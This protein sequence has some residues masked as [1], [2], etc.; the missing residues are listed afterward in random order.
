MWCR[1]SFGG[2]GFA[3]GAGVAVNPE[4]NVVYAANTATDVI[5]A[6]GLEP[7]APPLVVAD[8]ASEVTAT[9]VILGGEVDPDSLSPEE[10]AKLGQPA[11]LDTKYH[12]EYSTEP[13]AACAAADTCIE[14]PAGSIAPSFD[15]GSVVPAPVQGLTP[16]RT[17]HYR[18][19]ADNE[20][21]E[22]EHKRGEGEERTFTTRPPVNL[23]S[24]MAG[25]GN[26]SPVQKHGALI[27]PIDQEGVIM[28]A[29]DGDAIT[30]HAN[31]PIEPEPQGA[32]N[33]V[34]I[35]STRT[36]AGWSIARHRTVAQQCHRQA[37]R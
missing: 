21:G 26:G 27:E 31:A 11:E 8:Y 4:S 25:S 35:L 5:D 23:R 19:I 9:S 36:S 13:I 12:F 1:E 37:R 20:A 32:M 7:A 10:S 28:A 30:Y 33:E 18:L 6:F 22:A 15:T 29:A 2:G 14:T 16:G 34:Q 17:Y 3:G 24:R